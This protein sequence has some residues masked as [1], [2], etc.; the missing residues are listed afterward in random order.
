[1]G[2][3]P[4]KTAVNFFGF[5]AVPPRSVIDYAQ[6]LEGTDVVDY[7]WM[8]ELSTTWMPPSLWR[9]D[10]IGAAAQLEDCASFYDPAPL[11]GMAAGATD[12]LGI[13]L[14]TLT[15]KHGPAEQMQRMM[16]LADCVEGNAVF[17]VGVG[18]AYQTIPLGYKRSDGLKKFEDH[19]KLYERFWECDGPFTFE[20][21]IWKITDGYIGTTRNHKP[22]IYALGQGPKFLDIAARYADGWMTSAPF[23]YARPDW[24]AEK[25]HEVK[26]KVESYG[27]DPDEFGFGIMP[28]CL[29]SEDRAAIDAAYDNPAMK[30]LV[31]GMGRNVQ[32]D[33][34][35]E[36]VEP[37]YP[38]DWNYAVKWLPTRV[39]PEEL[40]HIVE[41]VPRRMVEAAWPFVGSAKEIAE[42]VQGY[43]EAGATLVAPFDYFPLFT[44]LESAFASLTSTIEVCRLLKP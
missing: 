26:Q 16:T 6:M 30:V 13:L 10:I 37:I 18:E 19:F 14:N 40:D 20:G 15:L 1:M 22:K 34:R 33:W 38:D 4:V 28:I 8:W 44:G 43:V 35:R 25:V 29:M 32:T 27:R 2:P 12:K 3:R 36:G 9:P 24:Y 23:A 31:A 17:C 5:R 41:Q 42:K 7:L 21:N 11:L 39:T